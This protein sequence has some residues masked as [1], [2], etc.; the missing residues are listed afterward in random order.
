MDMQRS[1]APWSSA[2]SARRWTPARAPDRWDA[3]AAL[4]RRSASTRTWSSTASS[5]STQPQLEALARRVIAGRPG[6][7][8]PDTEGARRHHGRA[9]R[10]VGLRG[11]VRRA[12]RLRARLPVRAGP[13]GL[14][15][16]H[17][18]RHARRADLHVPAHRVA[19]LPG[20]AHCRRRRRSAREAA[21]GRARTRS[22]ISTSRGTTASRRASRKEQREGRVVPQG[23]HRRRERRV[24]PAD[25]ADRAGGDRARARPSCSRARRAR[26]KSQLARRIYELKKAPAGRAASSSRSTARR[27]AATGRCRALFGHVQGRVHRARS[28]RAGASLRKAHE[29]GAVPRRDRRARASTSRPCCCARSRRRR[30]SRSAPTA[31]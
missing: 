28:R 9:R 11:G 22:S 30:S 13:G 12:P 25:R 16:P 8:S 15:R 21:R 20:A 24:Q 4:G 29:W 14:P 5:C 26:G 18:H 7:V 6:S 17:H 27:C 23:G 19:A 3:L 31:R 2:C 1:E 10:P